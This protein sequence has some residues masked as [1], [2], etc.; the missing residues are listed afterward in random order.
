[1]R[2]RREAVA[3]GAVGWGV[4][5]G[6]LP[7][8]VAARL[9]HPPR[10]VRLQNGPPPSRTPRR[11]TMRTAVWVGAVAF[12]VTGGPAGGQDTKPVVV[13][14]LEGHRGGV[15]SIVF[16]PQLPLVATGSGN[17]V[18]RLWDEKTGKLAFRMDPQKH[19]G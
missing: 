15:A 12:L 4:T 7:R 1:M 16:N 2:I 13:T 9:R 3:K 14:T 18:V 6:F 8:S 5:V 17:G 10:R 11:I 19:S